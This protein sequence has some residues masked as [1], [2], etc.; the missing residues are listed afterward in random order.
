MSTSRRTAP[1]C[2]GMHVQMGLEGVVSKRLDA[3]YR[4]GRS[5]DW[6]KVKNRTARQS[7]E[8][9]KGDGSGRSVNESG[10]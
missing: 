3:P 5:G 1:P 9:R 10:E 6:I 8:F 4:S 7:G 2:S